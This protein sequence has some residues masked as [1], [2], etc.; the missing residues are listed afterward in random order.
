MNKKATV[1]AALVCPAL[2]IAAL[3]AVMLTGCR[4]TPAEMPTVVQTQGTTDGETTEESIYGLGEGI[5]TEEDASPLPSE[6]ETTLPKESETAE[7]TQNNPE[8]STKHEEETTVP[9]QGGSDVPTQSET[10]VPTEGTA[11]PTDPPAMTLEAYE[12]LSAEE[13]EAYADSFTSKKAFIKWYNQAV[14]DY[15]E[16]DVIEVTGPVDLG[17]LKK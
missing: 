7:P 14:K 8:D 6:Q 11:E 3:T 5:L 2:L 12:A 4:N 9:T 13:Q 1:L 10:T 15:E 17:G 16:G